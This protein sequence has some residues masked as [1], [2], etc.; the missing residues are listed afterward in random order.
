MEEDSENSYDE[1]Y[2][3]AKEQGEILQKRIDMYESKIKKFT[4]KALQNLRISKQTNNPD[5][6][7][8]YKKDALIALKRK[9]FYEKELEK[10]M[11][12]K[13]NL[14][15]VIIDKDI[16]KQREILKKMEA[17]FH[18]KIA[19]LT[20][21]TINEEDDI[22]ELVIDMDINVLNKEY[23]KIINSKEI[24]DATEKFSVFNFILQ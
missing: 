6:S 15:M 19:V 22:P 24:K 10:E 17:D 14:D 5:L 1:E 13:I 18:R 8:R 12:K 23:D 4:E 20:G 7:D 16:A 3:E 9:K 11:D 21:S 2:E